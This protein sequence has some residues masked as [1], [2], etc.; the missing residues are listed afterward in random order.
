MLSSKIIHQHHKAKTQKY[1]GIYDVYWI[2]IE[3]MLLFSLFGLVLCFK[4]GSHEAQTGF[5]LQIP[6]ALV[7]SVLGLQTA[8]ML[9]CA[10]RNAC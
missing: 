3:R 10:K 9:I 4:I 5:E 6:P 2:Y 8:T 1:L 7:S